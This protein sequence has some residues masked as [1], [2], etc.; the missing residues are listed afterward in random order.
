MLVEQVVNRSVP[1]VRPG[2]DVLMAA[3]RLLECR[4]GVLPVVEEDGRGARVVGVLC[5]R[6]A[7]AATYAR[8]DPLAAMPVAAA[9]SPAACTCK[10]SDSLG[11]AVRLLRRSGTEALPVLDGDGYLVGVLSFADLVRE[12]TG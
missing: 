4:C 7:F 5:Y 1:T 10:A 6:D 8:T 11:L 3:R 9:M 2:D 12:V